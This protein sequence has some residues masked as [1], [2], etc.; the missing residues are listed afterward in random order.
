MNKECLNNN[1]ECCGKKDTEKSKYTIFINVLGIIFFIIIN[2]FGNGF[3]YKEYLMVLSFI[4][5]SYDIIINAV[6]SLFK[7]N[8]LDEHFLM[9][10]A[11][12]GA[13][14]LH[15][16]FE[17][18]SVV[19][20]YKLGEFIQNKA[21]DKY[22]ESIKNATQILPNL[23]NVKID[24]K[25]IVK[26]PS[27]IEIGSI[28]LVKPG[29]R[30]AIDGTVISGNA[31]IDLSAITGE[32][33][34][35]NVKVGT[36]ILS[37]SLN[38]DGVIEVKTTR[39]FEDSTSNKI[40][41]LIENA[42]SKKSSAEK[43]ITR[44][45]KIYTPVVVTLSILIVLIPLIFF[46]QDIATYINRALIFLVASCPCA[47]IISVPLGFFG[48]ISTASKNGILI[49]GSN[50]I[51]RLSKV[52]K[53]IFDKTG[54]LTQG[55]FTVLDIV[56]ESE[57]SKEEILKYIVLCESFSNHYIAKSILD[58]YLDTNKLNNEK[59]R[60][61]KEISGYGI[62]AIINSEKVLVGNY[63]LMKL[64][65]IKSSK[66]EIAGTVIYLSVNNE[67]KGYVIIA[68]TLKESSKHAILDIK[69]L[70]I[71]DIY[72]LTGDSRLIAKDIAEKL[73]IKNVYAELLPNDKFELLKKIKVKNDSIAFIGDGINDAPVLA[74][75]DIGIS[76]G[77]GSDLA[78]DTSDIVLLNDDPYKV[79]EAIKI[80]RK[81]KMIINENIFFA[82]F[83][84][85]LILVLG[86]FGIT[87]MWEAI[88]ADVGVS[89]IT[90]F[91]TFRLV[92]YNKNSYL[93]V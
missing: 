30:L 33:K 38:I 47:L 57:L 4:L 53:I 40:I 77:N 25:V 60:E 20:L 19:I 92:A 32:S 15:E 9:S 1:C 37:G 45:S 59:V 16:Y 18:M 82:I 21:S 43:F 58:Y 75:S 76:M 6:K 50:Y 42:L 10:I 64:N 56:S 85:I 34:P 79:V 3:I 26:N 80:S 12:I 17:A 67:Y 35:K 81:T 49:K 87:Q 5:I 39:R 88:F 62:S 7:K 28:I 91:N 72:M 89:L 52:N 2:I 93:K 73:N 51:D 48:G 74:E 27:D 46:K 90:I 68:D 71:D 14:F 23:V 13:L 61:Y 78:I 63:K 22:R 69:K 36:E 41:E 84:K 29:E 24:N 8:I 83:I 54:T 66:K 11:T 31:S 70:G 55:K 86:L 44:F 65:N